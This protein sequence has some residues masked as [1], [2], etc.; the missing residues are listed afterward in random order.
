MDGE[1]RFAWTTSWGASTRLVGGLIMVHGDDAGLILPPRVAP[2]QVIIVPIFRSDEERD[3]VRA[4]VDDLNHRLR[5]IVRL[6]VDWSD[7]RPG[8][9]YNEWEMR[10]V[11]L[12]LEIGPRDVAQSQ[13]MSVRR[14]TRTK[15]PIPFDALPE[16][17]PALLA[18]I[19]QSLFNRAKAF[20]ESR[21]WH[22]N[23]LDELADLIERERGFFWAPW[24]GSA[25]CEDNIK[26]RTGATLRCVPI[27]G[28][29]APGA[30][31][32]CAKPASQTAV[33]ARAY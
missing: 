21:T 27:E 32:V 29:D 33:F 24:C 13:A 2:Y 8:W 15:E 3:A 25:E 12:R 26:A 23:S 28:G 18:D 1:R 5:G 4:A 9:K 16:R 11:P 20:R 7:Q 6:H 17:L 31:L 30:C 22:V 19:Q 10:G 14:D